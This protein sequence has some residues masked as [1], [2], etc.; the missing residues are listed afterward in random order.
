MFY[1]V[2][3]KSSRQPT[4]PALYTCLIL[5]AGFTS[6]FS[7]PIAAFGGAGWRLWC[8]R[9]RLRRGAEG[10]GSCLETPTYNRCAGVALIFHFPPSPSLAF[11]S[12]SDPKNPANEFCSPLGRLRVCR[13]SRCR[14]WSVEEIT[15]AP[16][17][18]Y[19]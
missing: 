6:V 11:T 12:S 18:R 13:K 4:D 14:N 9:P 19:S 15:A 3:L 5:S 16:I 1:A 7:D 2:R 8:G 17:G 10:I